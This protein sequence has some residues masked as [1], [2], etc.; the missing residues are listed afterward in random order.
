MSLFNTP[1][2]THTHTHTLTHTHT[3]THTHTQTACSPEGKIKLIG[4]HSIG[5]HAGIVEICFG[6]HWKRICDE[7]D[8]WS[9]ADSVVTCR[10]LGY[11]SPERAES[12]GSHEQGWDTTPN[13]SVP[14]CHG[15]E[16][17]L[18]SCPSSPAPGNCAQHG[19]MVNCSLCTAVP[20]T[21]STTSLSLKPTSSSSR[22]TTS[23][24]QNPTATV[25]ALPSPTSQSYPTVQPTANTSKTTP[26]TKTGL[27]PVTSTNPEI[28]TTEPTGR[29]TE[30]TEVYSLNS[31]TV[32]IIGGITIGLLS[33]GLLSCLFIIIC[34]A[35]KR[36]RRSRKFRVEQNVAYVEHKQ[37][38]KQLQLSEAESLQEPIY[39]HIE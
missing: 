9:Q 32:R 37:M 28:P 34:T 39:E 1:H 5:E 15:H 3:H 25:A 21:T 18:N 2:Q 16:P 33:L 19:A 23:L 29:G 36:S 31:V 38:A 14:N 13:A 17:N 35:W 11:P 20:A 24:T 26:P 22:L 4:G 27:K 30:A 10:Q 7:G 8:G 6:G 12:L